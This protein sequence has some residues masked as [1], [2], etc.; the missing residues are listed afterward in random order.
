MS[1]VP[2][3]KTIDCRFN[4]I[5]SI[6]DDIGNLGSSLK[7]LRLRGNAVKSLPVSVGQLTTLE[8][9]HIA[10]NA[11][12]DLP[13]SLGQCIG[14]QFLHV[15]NNSIKKLPASLGGL[16]TLKEIDVCHNDLETL[17]DSFGELANLTNIMMTTNR[18][19]QIPAAAF[20]GLTGLQ[21][22]FLCYNKLTSLPETMTSLKSLSKADFNANRLSEFP[23]GVDVLPQFSWLELGWNKFT[24]IPQTILSLRSLMVLNLFGNAIAE[25]PKGISQMT[26]LRKLCLSYNRLRSLPDEMETL[27]LLNELHLDGNRMEI[28]PPVVYK[29][30]G[31]KELSMSNCSLTAVPAEIAQCTSMEILRFT[32]NRITDVNPSICSL[33]TLIDLDLSHNQLDRLPADLG[34]LTKLMDLDL[35]G[36]VLQVLPDSIGQM[37]DL[38]QLKVAYNRL[39]CLPL[40]N[41]TD[42][43]PPLNE[44]SH[45]H[46]AGAHKKGT[47]ISAAGN[48]ILQIMYERQID[49]ERF[50]LK[51]DKFEKK[52]AKKHSKYEPKLRKAADDSAASSSK[53][54]LSKSTHNLSRDGYS[55]D[56]VA[57]D[58]GIGS[59]SLPDSKRKVSAPPKPASSVN[60]RGSGSMS[61]VS[62]ANSAFAR[63]TTISNPK[64]PEDAATSSESDPSSE[65]EPTRG[66]QAGTAAT[67][68]SVTVVPRRSTTPAVPIPGKRSSNKDIS[69]DS[70]SSEAPNSPSVVVSPPATPASPSG[71]G[72]VTPTGAATP[73]SDS[74]EVTAAQRATT[75]DTE[76]EDLSD[77]PEEDESTDKPS[78][79]SGHK[80]VT[81]G[82]GAAAA[83]VPSKKDKSPR[84]NSGAVSDPETSSSSGAAADRMKRPKQVKPESPSKQPQQ[85]AQQQVPKIAEKDKTGKDK[86]KDKDKDKDK[87]QKPKKFKG[88]TLEI[89]LMATDV[90]AA[91]PGARRRSTMIREKIEFRQTAPEEVFRYR[92]RFGWAEMRGRR[93]DMQDTL[94]IL[95]NFAGVKDLF[96]LSAFDGHAGSVSAELAAKLMPIVVVNAIRSH[97]AKQLTKSL[98]QQSS[99]SSSSGSQPAQT[100]DS[101]KIT[102]TP[103]MIM[104]LD[105]DSSDKI[106]FNSFAE[107]HEAI[108]MAR[109]EDG[110]AALVALVYD[111]RSY[112]PSSPTLNSPSSSSDAQS[113]RNP[114]GLHA[115][116]PKSRHQIRSIAAAPG[117]TEAALSVVDATK[118]VSRMMIANS[119]D[120]RLVVCRAGKAV[121]VTVDHKPD[122]E[123]ELERIKHAGGFV[124]ENR[125]VNGVLAL[126]RAL[127]DMEL[128]PHVTY[129]PDV[130]FVDIRDDDEFLI[131]ACDGLWDVVTSEQAVKLVLQEGG[132]PIRSAAKLRDYAHA[133]NSTDNISVIVFRLND[134]QNRALRAKSVGSV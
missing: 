107:V 35:S 111:A 36:N 100:I 29:L 84:R 117:E 116:A 32:N 106:L 98:A 65:E 3:L 112:A 131:I 86:E 11:L 89:N 87:P 120:Q 12:S 59:A 76:G 18:L 37:H 61:A 127:G 21:Q 40:F 38:L 99:S 13:D 7:H 118:P 74:G 88:P 66:Q 78:P 133:L 105:Q 41:R 73:L 109:F 82:G 44:N 54:P 17:P 60:L 42:G 129:V 115:H 55:D 14:L 45:H 62:V 102:I 97:F 130:F 33:T 8:E 108:E 134:P 26:T 132:D 104:S 25:I 27:T 91:L 113:P 47:W 96:F 28:V 85:P 23:A 50:M 51:L 71:S 126:S 125:R 24:T 57:S 114:G 119:G 34:N 43:A 95:D 9:L 101:S 22:L 75:S 56:E 103:D 2:A 67:A 52:H 124:A 1:S 69:G 70:P 79:V 128:Q 122:S 81:S 83:G 92:R 53:H 16:K 5:E 68:D 58:D 6:P 49:E 46:A 30:H 63:R 80:R 39:R 110:T 77:I 48:V 72:Q 93:P 31:L 19:A 123:T 4:K 64:G 94:C 90:E 121:S 15:Y 20:S 10:H